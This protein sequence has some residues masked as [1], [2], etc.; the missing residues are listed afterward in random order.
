MAQAGQQGRRLGDGRAVGE[1]PE[2]GVLPEVAT[3]VTGYLLPLS[4][5]HGEPEKGAWLVFWGRE[6]EWWVQHHNLWLL[7]RE[8]ERVWGVERLGGCGLPGSCSGLGRPVAGFSSSTT[9]CI[10]TGPC[11][12]GGRTGEQLLGGNNFH[13]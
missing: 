4:R 5:F 2:E 12:P 8:R 13:C 6:G 9:A 7:Q 3:P 11:T 10:I 1:H